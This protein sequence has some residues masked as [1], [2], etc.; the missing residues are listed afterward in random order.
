M[1]RQKQNQRKTVSKKKEAKVAK[2]VDLKKGKSADC[3]SGRA[4]NELK[5]LVQ[6]FKK[7]G[8]G[9]CSSLNI[10]HEPFLENEDIWICKMSVTV[11]GVEHRTLGRGE[12][13]SSKADAAME[14]MK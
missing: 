13:L 7:Y 11:D 4:I 8:S 12:K 6:H 14:M 1:A 5:V 10:V 2:K 3:T 9:E